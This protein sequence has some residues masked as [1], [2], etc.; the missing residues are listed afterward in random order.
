MDPAIEYYKKLLTNM[1]YSRD[2][3]TNLSS[4]QNLQS[5]LYYQ[6]GWYASLV[7][8]SDCNYVLNSTTGA[9]LKPT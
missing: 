3:P 8:S 6:D 2:M 1:Y 9:F 4:D 5:K 7:W